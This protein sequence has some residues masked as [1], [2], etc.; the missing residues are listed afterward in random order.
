M[1]TSDQSEK[2]QSNSAAMT[3]SPDACILTLGIPSER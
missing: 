2:S 1:Q 3:S